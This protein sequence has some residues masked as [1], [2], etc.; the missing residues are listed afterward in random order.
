MNLASPSLSFLL[1][2]QAL[3]YKHIHLQSCTQQYVPTSISGEVCN[4][5]TSGSKWNCENDCYFFLKKVSKVL[6]PSTIGWTNGQRC[7]KLTLLAET[8]KQTMLKDILHGLHFNCIISID[9]TN[10]TNNTYKLLLYYYY[11]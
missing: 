4:F 5:C 8:N 11:Y 2:F 7:L 6:F 9:N 3:F 1:P 10:N